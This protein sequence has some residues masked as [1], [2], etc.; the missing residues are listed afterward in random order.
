MSRSLAPP[1]VWNRVR[2][3]EGGHSEFP[4]APDTCSERRRRYVCVTDVPPG[5]R[6]GARGRWTSESVISPSL[7]SGHRARRLLYPFPTQRAA[8]FRRFRYAC[9]LDYRRYTFARNPSC[10][11]CMSDVTSRGLSLSGSPDRWCCGVDWR[12]GP[13]E[14]PGSGTVLGQRRAKSSLERSTE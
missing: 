14:T 6:V 7:L 11:R 8:R 12:Q 4:V 5:A 3:R 13:L 10:T 9:L 2:G 1:N